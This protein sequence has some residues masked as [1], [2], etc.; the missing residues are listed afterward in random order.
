VPVAVTLYLD[1][2]VLKPVGFTSDCFKSISFD[3]DTFVNY[4]W[5]VTRWQ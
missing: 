1:M 4:D 2:T 3:I 5:V